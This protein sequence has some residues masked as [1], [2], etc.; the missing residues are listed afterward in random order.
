MNKEVAKYK[1][2]YK[3]LKIPNIEYPNEFIQFCEWSSIPKTM[4]KPETQ[5]ALA[6]KLGLN[7][8]TLS[9]WKL[10]PEYN[11]NTRA[12][13]RVFLGND[14]PELMYSVK[15]RA[16]SGSDKA[17]D[18]LLKWLGELQ[19]TEVQIDKAVVFTWVK[20]NSS[21]K[22]LSDDVVDTQ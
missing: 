9:N 19:D 15:K 14:L 13:L 8:Q 17:M 22:P 21:T 1:S 4:R 11:H 7:E 2:P 20:D 10:L 18:T 12:I 6:R 5:K 16:L 3:E